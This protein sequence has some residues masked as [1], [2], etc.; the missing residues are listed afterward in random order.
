VLGTLNAL[1]L[2]LN[3]ALRAFAPV[4][5]TSIFAWGVKWGFADGHLVWF[6]LVFLALTLIPACY[7]LPEAAEGRLKKPQQSDEEQ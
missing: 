1:A 5:F 6:F 7:F 2:T 4:L 3:S